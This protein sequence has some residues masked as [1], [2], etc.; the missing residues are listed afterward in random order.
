M[1]YL[2]GSKLNAVFGSG[3][4]KKVTLYIPFYNA[5]QYIDRVIPAIMMQSYPI[6]E[7]LIIDDGSNDNE[8]EAAKKYINKTKY[9]LR[10]L[11]HE[12]NMGL[13]ATRNTGFR[14]AQCEF[15]ASLDAD[16]I[17]ESDWLENLMSNFL[18]EKIAG[19][20]GKLIESVI[21]TNADKWR[22]SHMNQGWGSNKII[23]PNFLFGHSNVFRASAVK[24]VGYYGE[25][26]KTN[27]EDYNIS[28]SLYRAGYQLIYEPKAITKHLKTDTNKSVLD[29]RWR[30]GYWG[31]DPGLVISFK[32]FVGFLRQ[33]LPM[34][35]SDITNKRW[36]II[37][38]SLI[39]PFWSIYKDCEMWIKKKLPPK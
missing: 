31:F 29:A 28:Q 39:S 9:P 14:E 1:S 17:P 38:L 35:K 24:I 10:I 4:M 23:N 37:Y 34:L 32:R 33:T 20:G 2:I 11:S 27:A 15:V 8:I 22:A 13:G 5:S 25:Q 12:Y 7:V 18:N 30:Y 19:V 6:E 16:C 21:F 26:F 3:F 36:S